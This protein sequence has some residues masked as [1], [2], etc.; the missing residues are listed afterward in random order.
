M[1][2]MGGWYAGHLAN[3][4]DTSPPSPAVT[5]QV[6]HATS[7]LSIVLYIG[8]DALAALAV[9]LRHQIQLAICCTK[10]AG[11]A[12]NNMLVILLVPV[13]QAVA[14]C[15]FLAVAMVYAVY[16]ASLGKIEIHEFHGIPYRTFHFDD[17][18]WRCG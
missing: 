9:G 2:V 15:I 4:W 8:A 1:F 3:E 7:I 12:V 5:E 6:I 14:L 10:E 18:V 13:L 17:F 11:K 16:L